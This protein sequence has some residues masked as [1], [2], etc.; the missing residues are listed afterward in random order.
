MNW[1]LYP[2]VSSTSA[3][4]AL[5]DQRGQQGIDNCSS[6]VTP[7]LAMEVKYGEPALGFG[8]TSPTAIVCRAGPAAVVE[9]WHEDGVGDYG[10]RGTRW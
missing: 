3:V 8:H 5:E 2:F 10:P 4:A 6:A 1:S 7:F 9:G